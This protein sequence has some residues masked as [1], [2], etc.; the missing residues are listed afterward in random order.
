MQYRSEFNTLVNNNS[1]LEPMYGFEQNFVLNSNDAM[2]DLIQILII[3]L[4]KEII[5][6]V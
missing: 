3:Y 2:L 5:T 6:V 4:N 1:Q